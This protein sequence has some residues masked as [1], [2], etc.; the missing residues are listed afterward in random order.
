MTKFK[1]LIGLLLTTLVLA[2]S[3][4]VAQ[5]QFSNILFAAV[6][7]R[8]RTDDA[9][10]GDIWV[11]IHRTDGVV[12]EVQVTDTEFD[13]E[14]NPSIAM[15]SNG[16]MIVTWD[17]EGNTVYYSVLDLAGNF[18]QNPTALST[19]PNDRDACVAVTPNNVVFVVWESYDGASADDVAYVTMDV[20]GNNVSA[21]KRI[22]AVAQD[23][24]DPTVAAST[25][26]NDDDRVVIVWEDYDGVN[27]QVAFTILD[28]NGNTLV[29]KKTITTTTKSNE[30]INAAILP[31]GNTVIVWEGDGISPGDDVG[32]AI[33]DSS[34]GLV[35]PVTFLARPND[36]DSPCVAATPES[37]SIIVWD[38][39]DA[40]NNDDIW[41][42]V[43]G[44]NGNTIKP[45]SQL[46]VSDED[47]DEPD[48]AVDQTGKV[49]IIYEQ[50]LSPDDRIDFSILN[51]I[52]N[53]LG[54]GQLTDGIPDDTLDGD[55][56]WRQVA[57]R[58]GGQAPVGGIVA[59]VN[60]L[61]ILA[62]YLVL[63]GLIIVVST[64]YIIK[65]RKD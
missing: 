54:G 10:S 6:Y 33:I 47:V 9:D 21:E 57:T 7:E 39:E 31:N 19:G 49:V 63:V 36:I 51:S 61:M 52:G 30:E 41:Y 4:N 23:I 29:A 13:D 20:N 46:T 18:I 26:N 58:S 45:V 37:N 53:N 50:P 35:L 12:E 34:G 27:D 22:T 42:T 16:N 5:S 8:D 17:V 43:L 14:N 15:A 56:G 65:R 3:A 55:G 1:I 60:K 2:V 40:I 28:S 59:Q 11:N 32:Y 44:S 48:V 38:E 24:T 64:V 62:P 25:K